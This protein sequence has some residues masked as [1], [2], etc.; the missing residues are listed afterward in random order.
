MSL[1]QSIKQLLITS[2]PIG[3][4]LFSLC[5]VVGYLYSKGDLNSIFLLN[6]LAYTFPASLLAHGLNDVADS[7]FDKLNPRK[8]HWL[9]G[10]VLPPKY[11][12][13]VIIAS[14]LSG[15]LL[16]SFP[17]LLGKFEMFALVLFIIFLAW[18]YSFRPLRF[19][20]RVFL[21]LFTCL[22]GGWSLVL[23]GYN[24]KFNTAIFI[25][26]FGWSKIIAVSG[27][28]L[29]T[30]ILSYLADYEADKLVGEK[31]TVQFL[32][33]QL[34]LIFCLFCFVTSAFFFGLTFF[35][36]GL[37]IPIIMI[38]ASLLKVLNHGLLYKLAL[39]YL[40]LLSISYILIYGLK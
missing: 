16:L 33:P 23:I 8:K 20:S 29:G 24:Y 31:N 21:E 36:F 6:L 5:F 25:Q 15:I 3:W 27:F 13:L 9:T 10:G 34:S 17:I 11:N 37:I 35:S 2:R 30:S 1:L 39:I 22:A 38:T 4:F 7:D 28:I 19:K 26:Q 32:G 12:N 14:T 18:A 40:I